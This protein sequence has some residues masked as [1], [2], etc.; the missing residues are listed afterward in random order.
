MGCL[1]ARQR[2]ELARFGLLNNS[3]E[4][5][6]Q[7]LEAL[8]FRA[9]TKCEWFGPTEKGEEAANENLSD[10]AQ[11]REISCSGS[12]EVRIYFIMTRFR[13]WGVESSI[14]SIIE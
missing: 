12:S 8:K 2:R 3:K 10:R 5:E 11:L 6:E 9:E 7:E 1:V 13:A 14:K 4:K